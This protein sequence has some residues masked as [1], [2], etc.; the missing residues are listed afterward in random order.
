ML[1]EPLE[2]RKLLASVT[3]LTHGQSGN[4]TGWIA[5]AA[6]AIQK[7]DG[8]TA[9]ASEYVMD[10]DQSG[11]DLKVTSFKLESG[12]KPLDQ[13]T[14]GDAIIKLDWSNVSNGTVFTDEVAGV[15]ANYLLT[16]HTGVPDFTALPFHLIGHSRGASLMVSLSYDLG[17]RGIWV[18]QVTN[19]D[20][21]PISVSIPILGHFGDP[22]MATYSNTIFSD[23]YYR[24][25]GSDIID[26]HGQA[27][28]GSFN[29]DLNDSVQKKFLISAHLAVT[30]YYHG[31]IDLNAVENNDSVIFDSW[32]DHSAAKPPR[33]ATGFYYSEMVG[34]VR[35]VSGVGAAFGGTAERSSIKT[36]G[37]QWANI[38]NARVVGTTTIG[39]DQPITLKAVY[40][41]ADSTAKVTWFLD[42]DQ[43]PLNGNT[44]KV[45]A[46]QKVAE[47]S[48]PS[49]VTLNTVASGIATGTYFLGAK[50]FDADGHVRYVY[51]INK[52]SVEKADFASFKNGVVSVAGT[53]AADN[54]VVARDGSGASSVLHITRNG[55]TQTLDASDVT[56]VS[57]NA[58]E[59]NDTV[60]AES[61]SPNLYALGGAGN[62]ILV[63]AEGNDTLTGSGGNDRLSGNDGNDLLN[64]LSGRDLISGGNGNDRLFGDAGNDNLDAGAGNDHLEGGSGNDNLTGGTGNDTTIGNAGN[65]TIIANDG[66]ADSIDAGSGTDKGLVDD[67]DTSVSIETV[68]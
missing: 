47:S 7:R 16:Q 66:Q 6:D 37:T 23:T 36:K 29:L 12:N 53:G 18:D 33:D 49:G 62:D 59:G 42:K 58:G 54:I 24:T 11:G 10:V 17:Q 13:T 2:N 21:H 40:N 27:V 65:D 31:T 48:D 51:N 26:P 19:L 14:G 39:V 61:G 34:G 57:V 64:G 25:G 67:I 3:I 15:V 41:D 56:L 28:D 55:L 5:A 50:I 38:I 32:Y 22:K 46:T 4:I 8:G 43:N 68:L 9:A 35:P 60:V 44:A 63:G 45:F 30:G 52:L 20:P 1:L